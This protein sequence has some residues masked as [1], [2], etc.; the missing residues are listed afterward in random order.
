[1][2]QRCDLLLVEP[3]AA[4][5]RVQAVVFR[6]LG[7]TVRLVHTR[8]SALRAI[9]TAVYDLGVVDLFV[10]GGGPELA[11]ELARGVRRLVLSVGPSLA[12]AEV[13]AA[14]AGFPVHRKVAL[15]RVLRRRR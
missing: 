11:R 1:M 15:T 7:Y 13:L 5:G 6:R 9:R 4:Y 3:D 8:A 10:A 2:K 14:A 12:R